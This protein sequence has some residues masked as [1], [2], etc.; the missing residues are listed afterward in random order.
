MTGINNYK[1]FNCSRRGSSHI[2]KDIVCQ[3][4]SAKYYDANCRIFVVAD[5]HGDPS[6]FRSNVGSKIICETFI[7]ALK[8]FK[9]NIIDSNL[10]DSLI[11]SNEKTENI[12]YQLK[13]NIASEWIIKVNE[14][15]KN[16]PLSDEEKSKLDDK[17]NTYIQ[18]DKVEKFYGTTF[19]GGIL[20][21]NYLILMQQGDGHCFIFDGKGNCEEPIPWDERCIANV[22]TS[23]CD[24]DVVESIRHAMIDL[25]KNKIVACFAGS[26]GV[27]DSFPSIENTK[28]F[29]MDLIKTFIN[30]KDLERNKF[31]KILENM[32]DELSR[33]GSGDDISVAGIIEYKAVK[34]LIPIFEKLKECV[35][36]E[37][38]IKKIED[39]LIS[40]SRKRDNLESNYIKANNE[41]ELFLIDYEEAKDEY[42]EAYSDFELS[43]KLSKNIREKILETYNEKKC[44][45]EEIKI[46]KEKA[47]AKF[48]LIKNEYE[49]YNT[50]FSALETEKED[51]LKRKKG[52]NED[53][54]TL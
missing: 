50:K 46:E 52:V 28:I 1:I 35:I 14:H 7:S 4:S 29:Y 5:G 45:F 25:N 51:L 8:V 49:Q 11:G 20:T 13:V 37:Q 47:L 17:A 48:E 2:E 3:D 30:F 12:F 22:T 41:L 23:M 9:K 33:D 54:I 42:R 39:K 40:M 34:E 44:K 24:S 16:N 21:K 15:F 26:D 43:E 27:E 32:L 36:L 53:K 10:F 18:D 38:K 19:I 31:N 6:C